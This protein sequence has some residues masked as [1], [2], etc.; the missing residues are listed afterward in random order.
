MQTIFLAWLQAKTKSAVDKGV[1]DAAAAAHEAAAIAHEAADNARAATLQ[2]ERNLA[3]IDS[4]K[5]SL[6]GHLL[7][8]ERVATETKVLVNGDTAGKLKLAAVAA[9]EIAEK[10]KTAEDE[11]AAMLAWKA[12]QAH[13]KALSKDEVQLPGGGS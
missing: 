7:N 12:Y 2:S 8:I 9:R 10:T 4:N 13:L 6:D 1:N 11:A 3:K 5:L